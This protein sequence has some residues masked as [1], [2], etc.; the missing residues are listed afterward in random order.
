MSLF[1]NRLLELLSY[2]KPSKKTIV[3][4][5]IYST[6]NKICDILPE[7][8]LAVAVDVVV[9]QKESV[10]T[11]TLGIIDP[12]N[13]LYVIATAIIILW[14]LESL[15]E[16]LYFTTWH[17]LAQKIQHNLRLVTYKRIQ[18]LDLTYFEDKTIGGLLTVLQEDV[19]QLESFLSQGPNE[20]IQLIVNILVISAFFICISPF[21]FMLTI[22]PIPF[23][24]FIAYAF[25]HK[26][27]LLYKNMRNVT[28]SMASHVVYRLQGLT[29]IK[30][31]NT[32]EYELDSLAEESN[33]YQ[34]ASKD[35][36]NIVAQYIPLVRIV[37]MVGFI[38]TMIVGGINV[39][40]GKIAVYWYAELVFLIQRFLWPF[41][42][43]TNISDMYEKS[44]ASASRILNILNT[45][46]SIVD[47][48]QS[49][50]LR[51]CPGSI[52]FDHVSFTYSNGFEVFKNFNCIIPQRTTVAFVGSTGSGKSTLA[53]LLLRFYDV[54]SGSIKIDGHDIKDIKIHDL[55]ASI[56]LV[57]Q[58]VYIIDGTIAQN[59]AYG[60]FQASRDEIIKAATMAQIHDFIME[61]PQGYETRLEEYGKKLSGGQRQ[62]I[63]IARALLK[64]SCIFIFDEATSALDNETEA[65]INKAMETLK[66]SHTV[67]I[68]A[69]RLSTV[70]N[71]HT[72]FVIDNGMITESGTHEELLEKN[73]M[74]AQ[75]WNMQLK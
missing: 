27:S 29:T 53:K 31:Y 47:G 14:I 1:K 23:V 50:D 11:K 12:A 40:N 70:R 20:I 10:V 72:I 45:Q 41:A 35:V 3:L 59:I 19:N 56:G 7:I 74:Y 36:N 5:S 33:K 55:R 30:S 28:G 69:H 52:T 65:E 67:I 48:P 54:Q 58:D 57:S 42:T 68:I 43:L 25:Q 34:N 24:I 15:F 26:L 49:V 66:Y 2:I 71:A 62:R 61:F 21:L 13:Q 38:T 39:L 75:L 37:V 9:H 44:Q 46:P 4:A 8:L 51:S 63:S 18:S 16:Y 22:L 73:G 32:Q 17:H 64:K 6:L 60:T